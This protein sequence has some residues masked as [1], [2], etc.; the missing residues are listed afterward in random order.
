[1]AL[2]KYGAILHAAGE[3]TSFVW[4]LISFDLEWVQTGWETEGCD[5]WEEVRSSDFY[6]N[7]MAYVYSLNIAADFADLIGEDGSAFRSLA[8]TISVSAAAHYR[9]GFIYESD[10]RP[11]DG[12]VLHSIATFGE[13][14]YPPESPESADTIAV[15]VNQF[16]NEYPINQESIAA[17]EPGVLIG[18]YIYLVYSTC[19]HILCDIL[20]L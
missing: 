2:S 1:M 8:D 4:G 5:L 7:R 3:D 15:L 12:A 16:C 20:D 18:R 10:N 17:G 14:L 6:F 13:Y 11:Y 9:E 19:F